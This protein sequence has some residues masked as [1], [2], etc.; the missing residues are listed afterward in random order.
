M[1]LPTMLLLSTLLLPVPLFAQQPAD[2]SARMEGS[3]G[4]KGRPDGL[5][6]A[7]ADGDGR[8]TRDEMQAWLDRR[9]SAMDSDGDGAISVE[10]MQQMLGHQRGPREEGQGERGHG[11]DGPGGP[12]GAGG[13]SPGGPPPGPPPGSQRSETAPPPPPGRAMP[14]PEDGNEDGVIDR[15]EFSAPSLAMFH[16][17]DRNGDGVLSADEL[18]PSPPPGG[19]GGPED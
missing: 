15:A 18:P 5:W 11:R 9:F 14:Y 3:Q 4:D 13:S 7:D 16:D 10:A 6:A 2:L 12:G 19:E 8:I 1:R 17:L